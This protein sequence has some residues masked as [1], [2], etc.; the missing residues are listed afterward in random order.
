MMLTFYTS[1]IKRWYFKRWTNRRY[2]Y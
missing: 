2:T 1:S